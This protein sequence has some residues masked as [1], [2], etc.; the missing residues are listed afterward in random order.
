MKQ[1]QLFD[2]PDDFNLRPQWRPLFPESAMDMLASIRAMGWWQEI[3][4]RNKEL[5]YKPPREGKG[6][7][8]KN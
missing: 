8:W 3:E 1:E 7:R 2:L 5:R 6:G 4:R